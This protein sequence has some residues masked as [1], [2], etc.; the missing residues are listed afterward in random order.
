MVDKRLVNLFKRQPSLKPYLFITALCILA[1]IIL[2]LVMAQSLRVI[3][4]SAI[5]VN[6]GPFYTYLIVL[7]TTTALLSLCVGVKTF[8]TGHLSE[9]ISFNLRKKGTQKII[10]LPQS[11]L[12]TMH[13]GDSMSKLSNDLQL[14]R[15]FLE[16]DGY[17]LVL[18][19]LMAVTSLV[20]L[21]W[22]NWQLTLISLIVLP[23]L[24]LATSLLGK[25]IAKYSKGLQD[26]LSSMNN[27]TQDILG[28]V[29]IIKAF[30]LQEVVRQKFDK[31]VDRSLNRGVELGKK[32]AVLQSLTV[33][34]SFIPFLAT[35][36]IG[37][38]LTV[39]GSMQPGALLAFINL[40]NN[41]TF[42]I[43]QIPNHYGS[44]KT[45]M[46]GLKRIFKLLDEEKERDN[47]Q[48]FD[49]YEGETLVDIQNLTFGYN[50]NEVLKNLSFTVRKGETIA[51]VGP[52]GSGKST[53]FKL[54][55]GFYSGYSG[56]ISMFGKD[57]TKWNLDGLR[58]N[59]STVSQDTYLFPA[60]IMENLVLAKTGCS[61]EDMV[62]ASKIA[63]AHDFIQ[64]Q[65]DKYNT[66]VSER[67]DNLSGGQKQRLAIAR[68][69]LK[70]PK[71]LLLD[72]A[73][74]A[75]DTESEA[76]VQSALEK[77]M[78]GRTSIVIAHRLST[79]VKAD[80]ILVLD[81]GCIIEE[82]NHQELLAQKGFYYSLYHKQFKKNKGGVA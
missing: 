68:A 13:S 16:Y 60:T 17:F 32:R 22:L 33:A 37:G 24:I 6:Y 74:S 55:T 75:L 47:G 81:N 64:K 8:S 1:E 35:F 11:K 9:R 30:N 38:Y 80:R 72:E 54:L 57:L 42:P 66:K 39:I 53:I 79:I 45:A 23:V 7:L 63:N 4:D 27:S 25:P 18:R 14:I 40:L 34:F 19:P 36:G 62:R 44:Y 82:G 15:Q 71:L 5:E 67:G 70:N 21:L 31:Q 50:G 59:I 46:E 77:A 49:I 56:K 28:G 69:V 61:K 58:S 12:D 48:T 78:E 10:D 73:T 41:L 52:S 29:S 43:A 2:S 51:L 65:P 76:V 3:T 20:Y 26:E